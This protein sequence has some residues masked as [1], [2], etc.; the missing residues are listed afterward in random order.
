VRVIWYEA[1][2]SVEAIPLFTRLNVGRIPLTDAGLIKAALLSG[3]RSHLALPGVLG[4][5]YDISNIR[6][7]PQIEQIRFTGDIRRQIEELPDGAQIKLKVI[8]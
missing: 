6:T 7:V 5:E 3:V 2:V 1:P 4:G 8:E